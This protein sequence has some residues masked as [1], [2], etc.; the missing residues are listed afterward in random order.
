MRVTSLWSL[1]LVSVISMQP[2]AASGDARAPQAPKC[3]FP[4]QA[5]RRS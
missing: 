5:C 1:A 2:L 3:R 4:N